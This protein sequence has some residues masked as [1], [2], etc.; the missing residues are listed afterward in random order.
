MRLSDLAVTLIEASKSGGSGLGPALSLEVKLFVLPNSRILNSRSYT[1]A[2][3]NIYL[4]A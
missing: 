4:P 2:Y 1:D 3:G